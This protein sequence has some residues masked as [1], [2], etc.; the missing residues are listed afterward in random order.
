VARCQLPF[1]FNV[2]PKPQGPRFPAKHETRKRAQLEQTGGAPPAPGPRFVRPK[3]DGANVVAQRNPPANIN[4]HI[5][6]PAPAIDHHDAS[7]GPQP[8]K[9]SPSI[10][11]SLLLSLGP[12]RNAGPSRSAAPTEVFDQ[13]ITPQITDE[14][15]FPTLREVNPESRPITG[16]ARVWLKGVGFPAHFPLYARFGTAVVLTVSPVYLSYGPYLIGSDVLHRRSSYLLFAACNHVRCCR[17]YAFKRS[18]VTCAGVWD[19]CRKISVHKRPGPIVG[20]LI[21]TPCRVLM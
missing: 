16:G 15:R 8:N 5:N 18:P 21:C 17:C 7:I 10:S 19:Q 2:M 9:G 1:S 3:V 20:F 14:Q 13:A 4:E 11:P 6:H 12:P